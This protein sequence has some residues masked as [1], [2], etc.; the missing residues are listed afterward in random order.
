MAYKYERITP[1][2]EVIENE[3]GVFT[4]KEGAVYHWEFRLFEDVVELMFQQEKEKRQCK[5]D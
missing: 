5:C 4:K 2:C 3:A 1:K